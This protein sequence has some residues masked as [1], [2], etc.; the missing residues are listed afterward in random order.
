MSAPSSA[1][2]FQRDLRTR[3]SAAM[4][5]SASQ[6]AA[7]QETA[8]LSSAYAGVKGTGA[9]RRSQINQPPHASAAQFNPRP[10][11]FDTSTFRS[12][13]ANS[14]YNSLQAR[15]QQRLT[16][17]SRCSSS[18]TWSKSIDERPDSSRAPAIQIFRRTATTR[19][20]S[21]DVPISICDR[22]SL[23]YAYDLPVAKGHR[24]L[25]GWQ[26]FGI[27]TSRLERE[28]PEGLPATQQAMALRHGRS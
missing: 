5:F 24:L 27:L 18:Y 10:L 15:L 2:A 22:L 19:A 13:S 28:N 11:Q 6:Q 8:S 9:D 7:L 21:E 25:G 4:D 17:G 3:Y 23:S 20:R 14:S 1:L 16:P 26:T 12:R